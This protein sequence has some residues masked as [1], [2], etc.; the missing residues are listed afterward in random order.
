MSSSGNYAELIR[1]SAGSGKTFQLTARILA[2]LLMGEDPAAIL[3]TTFTRKAAGEIRARL[4]ARLARAVLDP[5]YFDNLKGELVALGLVKESEIRLDAATSAL[6]LI[7][8][9]Q[10]RLSICTLDAFVFTLAGLYY[11]EGGIS[12][13]PQILATDEA[14]EMQLSILTSLIKEVTIGPLRL[15]LRE[16]N[17]HQS[18]RSVLGPLSALAEVFGV[19]DASTSTLSWFTE[20]RC[21]DE[22]HGHLTEIPRSLYNPLE[23]PTLPKTQKG[24]V[25]SRWQKAL[26]K[27]IDQ[28]EHKDWSNCLGSTFAKTLLGNATY[29]NKLAE[30]ALIDA[31]TPLLECAMS[32]LRRDI[33]K[34]G[35]TFLALSQDYH[36]IKS[37]L[38]EDRSRF[39]FNGLTAHLARHLDGDSLHTVFFRLDTKF[40]HLLLDEFQD[41]S[42]LQWRLLEPLADEILASPSAERTFLCV[43]DTKQAIYGWRGGVAALFDG[44]ELRYSSVLTA[45]PLNTCY[46][47]AP[48]ILRFVDKLFTGLATTTALDNYQEHAAAW[49]SR[50]T[51]HTSALERN[52]DGFVMVCRAASDEDAEATETNTEE[53][54]ADAT[55]NYSIDA[56]TI[57]IAKAVRSVLGEIIRADGRSPKDITVGILTRGNSAVQAL[58]TLLKDIGHDEGL[59]GA[60][61]SG[62]GGAPLAEVPIVSLVIS[63]LKFID[64]PQDTLSRYHIAVSPLGAALQLSYQETEVR[65]QSLRRTLMQDWIA[66]GLA[67]ALRVLLAPITHS[68]SPEDCEALSAAL[69]LIEKVEV[70]SGILRTSAHQAVLN[71]AVSPGG[72]IA[73]IRIMTIHK[74]KGLEFDYVI[75]PELAV[76]LVK[77]SAKGPVLIE[78]CPITGEP[79]RF[80]PRVPKDL[81]E[82]FPEVPTATIRHQEEI[83]AIEDSLSLLYVALT[84]AE[85]GIVIIDADAT[86]KRVKGATYISL[87]RAV[88]EGR[89]LN[90]DSQVVVEGA[91][92]IRAKIPNQETHS[93]EWGPVS[94]TPYSSSLGSSSLALT[95][96]SHRH[97]PH[98]VLSQTQAWSAENKEQ[99]LEE[100]FRQSALH[101][102]ALGVL[103]QVDWLNFE[104]QHRKSELL[105]IAEGMDDAV[106]DYLLSLCEQKQV[107]DVFCAEHL[108]P[109]L[110]TCEEI[111]VWRKRRFFVREN[112]GYLSGTFYRVVVGHK[113]NVP[114]QALLVLDNSRDQSFY[115]RALARILPL[116]TAAITVL[117]IDPDEAT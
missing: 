40:R 23:Q 42:L 109:Q 111:T 27:V 107:L 98:R 51:S 56:S 104:A 84:R 38:R 99:S 88:F 35:Q 8:K 92:N 67:S 113:R 112:K 21:E 39:D 46:R 62:E 101:R 87:I 63:I 25:D 60:A 47:C 29:Y 93:Q 54:S 12:E 95:A 86:G 36:R 114:V 34:R 26:D 100:F 55:G 117:L 59:A 108:P 28:L 32:F 44:L 102:Q 50:Y 43:G 106:I 96:R 3:A 85:R 105:K 5:I 2:L 18:K 19:L 11:L 65:W 110:A 33:H 97:L 80:Y 94:T 77:S 75:L 13:T 89:Y 64:H 49:L 91:F 90:E 66:A 9:A 68:L 81:E 69:A 53:Q 17:N 1:A 71:Q 14:K 10:P 79:L 74:S 70:R 4:F 116:D 58:Q 6:A 24:A 82:Y 48:A 76:E 103:S 72:A 41:T 20:A 30:S 57:A 7:I 22:D 52:G 15:S 37:K 61:C 73:P 45:T 16:L 78:R 31:A 83:H 115:V